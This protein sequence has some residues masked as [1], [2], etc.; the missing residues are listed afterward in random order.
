MHTFISSSSILNYMLEDI[1][2]EDQL[3]DQYEV[4]LQWFVLGSMDHIETTIGYEISKDYISQSKT[5]NDYNY[6]VQ[7][8]VSYYN[9]MRTRMGLN[10]PILKPYN[11][12]EAV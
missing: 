2:T 9:K 1:M 11:S 8:C 6:R 12:E 10:A 3:I 7:E 4:L 5:T